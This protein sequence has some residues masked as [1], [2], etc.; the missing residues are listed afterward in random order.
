MVYLK[1]R[2]MIYTQNVF[3]H[4]VQKY[5]TINEKRFTYNFYL[6]YITKK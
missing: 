3:V 2:L 6:K 5:H 4:Q 1:N